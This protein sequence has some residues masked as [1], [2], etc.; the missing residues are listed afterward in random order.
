MKYYRKEA[1]FFQE[2]GRI[3]ADS[4][5]MINPPRIPWTLSEREK[6][7][8]RVE[9]DF[10]VLF[11]YIDRLET[12]IGVLEKNIV[13]YNM[14]KEGFLGWLKSEVNALLHSNSRTHS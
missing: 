2:V 12:R 1:Q 4:L 9:E 3:F 7:R 13:T 8:I 5:R 14:G 11:Q 6:R 10:D